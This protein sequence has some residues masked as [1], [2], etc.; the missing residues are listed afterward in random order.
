MIHSFLVFSLYFI[1][2]LFFYLSFL[3]FLSDVTERISR[4]EA[5]PVGEP[6]ADG[7]DRSA[8]EPPPPPP[9]TS[10]PAPAAR[11]RHEI[12]PCRQQHPDKNRSVLVLVKRAPSQRQSFAR[13]L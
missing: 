11:G 13:R 12:V 10:S 1:R 6:A 8:A 5:A 3:A 2:M 9:P 7:D 4:S